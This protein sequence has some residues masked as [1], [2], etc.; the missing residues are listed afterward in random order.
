MK[1]VNDRIWAVYC[2]TRRRTR[3]QYARYYGRYETVE[4]AIERVKEEFED[5]VE[6]RLENKSNGDILIGY[7]YYND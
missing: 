2:R 6:Y 3:W 5:P 4:Q 7:A 1:N